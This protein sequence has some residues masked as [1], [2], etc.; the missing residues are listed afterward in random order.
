LL[1]VQPPAGSA[2]SVQ[3]SPQVSP[4]QRVS[5]V[6]GDVLIPAP[7]LTAAATSLSFPVGGLPA[8]TFF[9]RLRVDGLDSLPVTNPP[10]P[11]DPHQVTLP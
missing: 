10:S 5:L 3:C 8:G 9:L 4:Q 6:I 1:A 2:V 11:P 7:T